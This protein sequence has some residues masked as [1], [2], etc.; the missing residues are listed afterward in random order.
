MGKQLLF[1]GLFAIVFTITAFLHGQ[2]VGRWVPLPPIQEYTQRLSK[3]PPQ[4]GEWS[5]T[6]A[7][8]DD[9]DSLASAGINAFFS[10]I[11]QHSRTGEQV[12]VLIVCGRPGPISVHTPD[13]CYR[14][15]GYVPITEPAL[16][17]RKL[18]AEQAVKLW[19]MSFSPPSSRLGSA[20]LEIEWTWISNTGMQS[21]ANARLAF[22]SS[23]ALYKIYLIREQSP[24][25]KDLID[26][27]TK[28]D[29]DAGKFHAL[30]LSMVEEILLQNP[31][32]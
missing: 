8:L 6:E 2:L 14:G 1:P 4:I 15:A 7:P 18:S 31:A 16:I 28:V 5:A 21:P 30:F 32:I 9:P 13:V 19:K 29:Q 10:K 11:Y 3:I 22:A 17:D 26:K 24:V 25:N 27:S 23:P 20:P 12:S